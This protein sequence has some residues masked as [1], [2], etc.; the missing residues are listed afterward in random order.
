[1]SLA[2]EETVVEENPYHNS[3]RNGIKLVPQPSSDPA[4]PLVIPLS[5]GEGPLPLLIHDRTRI[6][7]KH[8]RIPSWLYYASPPSPPLHQP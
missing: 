2:K 3:S 4:D 8:E 5:K 6:G 1:M 7:R